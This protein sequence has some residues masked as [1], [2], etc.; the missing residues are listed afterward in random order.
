MAV[1]GQVVL[2]TGAARGLGQAF[3]RGFLKEGAKVIA[4]A[5]TWTPTGL[6]GDDIDFLAEI[7]D[8]PNVLVESMDITLDDDVQLVYKAA[9]TSF[10]RVDVMINNAGMRTE[11]LC[12]Y[13]QHAHHSDRGR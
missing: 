13:W 1:A 8:N 2:I 7:R 4:T 3:V 10:G 12:T 11:I 9:I 5:R 6:S